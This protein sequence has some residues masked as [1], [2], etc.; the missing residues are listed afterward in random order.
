MSSAS[1]V[2]FIE[3]LPALWYFWRDKVAKQHIYILNMIL[4]VM[5]NNIIFLMI[6]HYIFMHFIVSLNTRM[7]EYHNYTTMYIMYDSLFS[8]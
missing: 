4:Q 8:S 1:V 3:L 2:V 6:F 5:H 7:H